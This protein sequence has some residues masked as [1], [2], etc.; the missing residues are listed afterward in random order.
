MTM[1]ES[2]QSRSFR[3]A[4]E[5]LRFYRVLRRS[6]DVPLHFADQVLRAGTATGANVEEP[7]SASS[8]RDMAAKYAIGLRDVRECHYWLRLIKAD[9]PQCAAT[10]DVLLEEC[11]QLINVLT[12]AIRKLRLARVAQ[13]AT[14]AIVV[15]LILASVACTIA[16]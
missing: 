5:I 4:L 14:I 3:L 9:Q 12:P 6:T 16:G 10:I 11:S 13:T 15:I 2:F 1:P 7:K 8:R